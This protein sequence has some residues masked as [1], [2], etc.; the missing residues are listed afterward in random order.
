M[1][2]SPLMHPV[3]QQIV[4]LCRYDGRCNLTR[5]MWIR[6]RYTIDRKRICKNM[7]HNDIC[8]L[9]SVRRKGT[10]MKA[11]W[12]PNA[13]HSHCRMRNTIIHTNSSAPVSFSALLSQLLVL[14]KLYILTTHLVIIDFL[15]FFYFFYFLYSIIEKCYSIISF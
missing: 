15:L 3:D 8:A 7:I 14:N 9:D 6:M 1:A 11:S 10:G 12:T 5:Q 2:S 4:L 13:L